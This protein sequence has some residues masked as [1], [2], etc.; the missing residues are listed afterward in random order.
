MAQYS[1]LNK[2]ELLEILEPYSI[3][4]IKSYEILGG[5]SENTNYKID[6]LEKIYESAPKC[7]FSRFSYFN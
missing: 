1:I 6:S 3:S 4:E 5:G 2:V 7:L